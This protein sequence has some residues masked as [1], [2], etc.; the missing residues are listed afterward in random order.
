MGIFLLGFIYKILIV[1]LLMKYYQK[2]R[3]IIFNYLLRQ[4]KCD[5]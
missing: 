3:E 1:L 2:E 5:A 4:I